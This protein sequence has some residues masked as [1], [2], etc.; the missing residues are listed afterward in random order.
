MEHIYTKKIFIYLKFTFNRA[1]CIL[2]GN[3][4][5]EPGNHGNIHVGKRFTAPSLWSH[6]W[7]L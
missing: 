4:I 6:I 2:L 3:P 7:S 5:W 1:S